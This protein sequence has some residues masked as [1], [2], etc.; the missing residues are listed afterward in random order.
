LSLVHTTA[1]V[2]GLVKCAPPVRVVRLSAWT[3]KSQ[4]RPCIVQSYRRAYDWFGD[5]KCTDISQVMQFGIGQ[6]TQRKTVS[7]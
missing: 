1:G 3:M 7:L 2:D 4:P 5:P 6:F